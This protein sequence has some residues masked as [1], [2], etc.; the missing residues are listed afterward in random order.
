MKIK[1]LLGIIASIL[2]IINILAYMSNK[3]S[4]SESTTITNIEYVTIRDTVIKEVF[5]KDFF[6]VKVT[7][8]V[9]IDTISHDNVKE[10]TLVFD[11]NKLNLEQ[12]W[13]VK[14]EEDSL[15]SS[16]YSIKD[17]LITIIDSVYITNTTHSRELIPQRGVV[18]G[19]GLGYNNSFGWKSDIEIGYQIRSGWI[20]SIQGTVLDNKLFL[21][22]KIQKVF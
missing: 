17:T 13:V 10:R 19:A 11:D 5:I 7:D 3:N 9:Y 14:H 21:G 8:T 1:G 12:V 15:I 20:F 4:S 18:V 2:I 6:P 16:S 22:P